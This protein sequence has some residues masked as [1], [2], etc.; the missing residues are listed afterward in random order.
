VFEFTPVEQHL[1]QL[2]FS[3]KIDAVAESKTPLE[4]SV[5][6]AKAHNT[7]AAP[8]AKSP[9]KRDL[10]PLDRPPCC[11]PAIVQQQMTGSA[12]QLHDG[13][14]AAT[15]LFN[16]APLGHLELPLSHLLPVPDPFPIWDSE[17]TWLNP[18]EFF[19]DVEFDTQEDRVESVDDLLELA[20]AGPLPEPKFRALEQAVNATQSSAGSVVKLNPEHLPEYLEHNPAV[21]VLILDNTL[22]H[23]T[24][25]DMDPY[26]EKY[27]DLDVT[28]NTVEVLSKLIEKKH[29][30]PAPF[31]NMYISNATRWCNALGKDDQVLR[32]PVR[33][34]AVFLEFL[35]QSEIIDLKGDSKDLILDIATFCSLH[36]AY[37][38]VTRLYGIFS[39]KADPKTLKSLK[40]KVVKPPKQSSGGGGGSSNSKKKKKK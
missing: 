15:Q 40:E 38:N 4:F 32:R 22:T 26:Y 16:T 11:V 33:L 30:L 34:L 24:K 7:F 18:S 20:R 36:S 17:L 13:E 23:G 28:L 27:V 35:I 14:E 9:P 21:V 12:S 3:S 1:S 25:D 5:E 39:V 6:F 19:F 10:A 37:K 31:L 29:K 2:I 8:C